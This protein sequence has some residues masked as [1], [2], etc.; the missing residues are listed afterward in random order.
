MLRII[1]NTIR[2]ER[3]K[4]RNFH[5]QT[6]R[7]HGWGNLGWG[8]DKGSGVGDN[9]VVGLTVV[10]IITIAVV[11]DV[12]GE[13]GDIND[14]EVDESIDNG[15]VNSDNDDDKDNDSNSNNH[16]NYG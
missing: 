11:V 14:H 4:A 6:Q 15:V 2:T 16:N 1:R 13:D 12:Y 3:D 5:C 10:F 8:L 7:R 9:V